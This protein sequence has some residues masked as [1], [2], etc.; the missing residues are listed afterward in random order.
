MLLLAGVAALLDPPRA[1][2]RADDRAR[3]ELVEVLAHPAAGGVLRRRDADVVAAVVLDVEVAVEALRQGDL[4]QPALVALLL[5]A[6][7]VRGVDADAA[8]AADRDREADLGPQRQLAVHAQRVTAGDE[9]HRGHEADVLDRQEEVGDPAVVAVLLQ[10]LDHVVGR[11]GAVEA[12]EQVDRRARSPGSRPGRSRTAPASRWPAS[13]RTRGRTG[14][15]P[16]GR[17]ATGSAWG[18]ATARSSRPGRCCWRSCPSVPPRC[19]LQDHRIC[20]AV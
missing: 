14:W 7:L 18:R 9:V 5:V 20:K 6:E 2:D 10:R 8:D 3:P 1:L 17:S 16:R 12:G 4:G 15:A 19:G 11:V 13:R